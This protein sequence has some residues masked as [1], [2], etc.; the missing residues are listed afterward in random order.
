[1][2]RA[3][4]FLFLLAARVLSP[5]LQVLAAWALIAAMRELIHELVETRRFR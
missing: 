3:P 2:I 5:P 4:A 1:M